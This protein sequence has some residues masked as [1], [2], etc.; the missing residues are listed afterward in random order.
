VSD[1]AL[2]AAG[3]PLPRPRRF[4]ARTVA[5]AAV[6]GGAASLALFALA[7][8]AGDDAA[9][10]PG[11]AHTAPDERFLIDVPRGWHSVDGDELAAIDSKPAA[12]LRR[13]DRR[14]IVIVRRTAPVTGT[15]RELS[16][17]VGEQLRGRFPGFRRVSARMTTIDGAR[18]FVYTFVREPAGTVQSLALVSAHGQS[19]AI[20][21][22]VPGNAPDVAREIGPIVASFR[23]R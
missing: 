5:G 22:V 7:G 2:S 1:H 9:P 13:D 23:A 16:R 18:A 12:V 14:G 17:T 8:P 21:S 4:G 11:T 3:A 15:S 20:D 19:Y 10:V 6:A